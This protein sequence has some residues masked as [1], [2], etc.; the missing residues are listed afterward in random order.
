V[1]LTLDTNILAY[2]EGVNGAPMK[3][4]ALQLV[5]RLPQEETFLPVQV[6]GELFNLLVRKAGRTPA[7]ARSAILS[8]QDAFPLIETSPAVM[9]S[10]ADLAANHRFPIWDAVILSAAAAAGSRLVLSE[11]LQ[12]GFTWNGV[13]ITN[14]F[15]QSRHELLTALLDDTAE[16]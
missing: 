16:S 2:A 14:P 4:L 15:S 11:D 5:Q 1:R 13:T 3:K 12:E 8:W 7:K 9:L 10:A 6:L